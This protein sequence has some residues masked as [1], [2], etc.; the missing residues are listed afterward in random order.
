MNYKNLIVI[1]SVLFFS[2]NLFAKQTLINAD[3]LIDVDNGL[4][5]KN[6][7]VLI[8]DNKIIQVAKQGEID[9]NKDLIIID[10]KG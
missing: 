8:E 2:S 5:I 6:V 4:T 9:V 1:C 3:A 7:S 10:L